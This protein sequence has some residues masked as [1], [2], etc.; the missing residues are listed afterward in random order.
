MSAAATERTTAD[1]RHIHVHPDERL[2]VLKT[3]E[4]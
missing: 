2:T 1:Q 4:T 3:R